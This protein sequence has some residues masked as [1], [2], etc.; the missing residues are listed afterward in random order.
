MGIAL[1]MIPDY[2]ELPEENYYKKR[3][4]EKMDQEIMEADVNFCGKT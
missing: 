1:S 4:S 2:W 3:I